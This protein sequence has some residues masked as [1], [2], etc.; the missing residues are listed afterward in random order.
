MI[1]STTTAATMVSWKGTVASKNWLNNLGCDLLWN[2]PMDD[3]VKK[4]PWRLPVQ[5]QSNDPFKPFIYQ[6]TQSFF[7]PCHCI[8]NLSIH[9]LSLIQCR[10]IG[11]YTHCRRMRGG[12]HPG[13]VAN[14]LQDWHRE[15]VNHSYAPINLIHACLCYWGRKPEYQDKTQT[16]T[17]KKHTQTSHRSTMIWF[18]PRTF[19]LYSDSANHHTAVLPCIKI[20]VE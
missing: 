4:Q 3:A 5:H 2:V 14:L 18:E 13:Q 15:I 8:F 17:E 6:L 11:S 16:D 7:I 20:L 10:D 9:S 12:L 1:A 19:L